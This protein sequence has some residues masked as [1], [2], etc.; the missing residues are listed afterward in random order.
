LTK[1]GTNSKLTG[2][3]FNSKIGDKFNIPKQ[4]DILFT[5]TFKKSNRRTALGQRLVEAEDMTL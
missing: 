1:N 3:N 5:V 2:K 4:E